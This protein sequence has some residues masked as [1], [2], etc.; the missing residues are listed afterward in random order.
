MADQFMRIGGRGEDGTAKPL[1]T[2]NDGNIITKGIQ[3]GE[4]IL[5]I[6]SENT[7]S[8]ELFTDGFSSMLITISTPDSVTKKR[9]RFRGQPRDGVSGYANI[10]LRVFDIQTG[11]IYEELNESSSHGVGRTFRIDT[12]GLRSVRILLSNY[13]G[14]GSVTFRILPINDNID[15]S[16]RFIRND[17]SDVFHAL[18]M[19]DSPTLGKPINIYG[20]NTAILYV[21]V[22]SDGFFKV[23]PKTRVRQTL[24]GNAGWIAPKVFDENGRVLDSITRKGI[25]YVDVKN[26]TE[27][28][29]ELVEVEGNVNAYVTFTNVPLPAEYDV[30]HRNRLESNTKKTKRPK[31]TLKLQEIAITGLRSVDHDGY[32]YFINSGVIKRTNDSGVTEEVGFDF[33]DPESGGEEGIRVRNFQKTHHGYIAICDK[34]G[35]TENAGSIWFSESFDSGFTKRVLWQ[36]NG[37]DQYH[38]PNSFGSIAFHLF[39]PHAFNDICMVGEYTQGLTGKDHYTYLSKDGGQSWEQAHI[40][41]PNDPTRQLHCHAVTYNPYTG[42]CFI[43][44]G[45]GDNAELYWSSDL[46]QNWH[47]AIPDNNTYN[48]VRG[49]NSTLLISRPNKVILGNDGGRPGGLHSL[50]FRNLDIN[51]TNTDVMEQITAD[52][53][54]EY[55]FNARMTSSGFHFPI[56]SVVNHENDI[57]VTF[58]SSNLGLMDLLASGDG[59]ESWHSV[60]SYRTTGEGSVTTRVIGYDANDY[61]YL[62]IRKAD[63]SSAW[64]KAKKLEWE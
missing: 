49:V 56:H 44:Y 18:A 34:E 59:G 22:G 7:T 39:N 61:L 23:Q 63:G 30:S 58:N 51:K 24:A 41:S 8:E 11:A 28:F 15:V 14:T 36:D 57:Y 20:F 48:Y 27:L 10:P 60:F 25:Y 13:E 43:S 1:Q 32:L 54:E 52:I 38:T 45:D 5:K 37:E 16:P 55:T 53:I 6:F 35:E 3:K 31:N 42:H 33:N 47:K 12:H 19:E 21:G 62:S 40:Q 64:H 29:A 9:V 17:K 50:V 4:E 2:D 26:I 46:G